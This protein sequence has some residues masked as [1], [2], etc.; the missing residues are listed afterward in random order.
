[1]ADTVIRRAEAADLP[2]LQALWESVFGDPPEFIQTFFTHFPPETSGWV[3][4]CGTEIC[5]A[6]YLL[7]GNR[8]IYSGQSHPCTYVYAVATPEMQRG[9]GYASRLMRYFAQL[10]DAR[11]FALYTRPAEPGLFAWYREV[12]NASGIGTGSETT[13][14]RNPNCQPYLPVQTKTAAEYARLREAQ[15]ADIP[16]IALSEAFLKLQAEYSALLQVGDGCAV[17]EAEEGTLFV[18]ELLIPET[19][20][21]AAI[22]ALLQHFCLETAIVLQQGQSE[23]AQPLAAFCPQPSTPCCPINWGLFLD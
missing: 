14:S 4:S 17:A 23:T 8:L 11:G 16:H 13:V 10:A 5:S 3:V 9:H 21:K 22:Q 6:A 20:R 1:M 12:M 2:A 18:K 19:Q 15:L 7:P